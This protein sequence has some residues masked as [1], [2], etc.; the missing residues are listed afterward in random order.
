MDPSNRQSIKPLL[1][2]EIAK[3]RKMMKSK[4]TFEFRATI[5][6]QRRNLSTVTCVR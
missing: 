2:L 6:L 1:N 3:V 5:M 4:L